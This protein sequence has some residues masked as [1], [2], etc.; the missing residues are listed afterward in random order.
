M[1]VILK[2][3]GEHVKVGELANYDEMHK[4]IGGSFE[5]VPFNCADGSKYLIVCNDEFLLNGS[6]FNI[7]IGGTQFFGNIFICGFGLV[8]GEHDFI[9]LNADDIFSISNNL[10][11]SPQEQGLLDLGAL[12]VSFADPGLERGGSNGCTS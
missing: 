3:P 11:W 10:C 8:N 12:A 9:G 5:T 1:R 7:S 4:F 2:R 6:K